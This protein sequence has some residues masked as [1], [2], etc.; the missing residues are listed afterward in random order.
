MRHLTGILLGSWLIFL[1]YGW[2]VK[3]L[4]A[5]DDD[6]VNLIACQRVLPQPGVQCR[7]E[8]SAGLWQ[9]ATQTSFQLRQVTLK[10]YRDSCGENDCDYLMLHLDTDGVVIEIRDFQND[11]ARANT[12]K[13]RL[14]ALLNQANNREQVNLRYGNSLSKEFLKVLLFGLTVA[15]WLIT[16]SMVTVWMNPKHSDN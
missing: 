3:A 1:P 7:H 9:P 8:Q 5:N 10:T 12:Q 16:M 2:A 11:N 6:K 14:E 15:V 4:N 13:D